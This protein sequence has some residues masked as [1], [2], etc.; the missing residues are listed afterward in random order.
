MKDPSR[1]ARFRRALCLSLLVIAICVCVYPY[2][3][4]Q[5]HRD[6]TPAERLVLMKPFDAMN[7]VILPF[8]KT[9]DLELDPSSAAFNENSSVPIKGV[10]GG[11][12]EWNCIVKQNS[13]R[14]NVHLKPMMERIEQLTQSG[15]YEEVKPLRQEMNRWSH[16]N[17]G[18]ELNSEAL[19]S[20]AEPGRNMELSI[21]GVAKG[22]VVADDNGA[23]VESNRYILAFG[24]WQAAKHDAATSAD[25]FHFVHQPQTPFVEN[26]V[27][28][29]SG[30]EDLIKE[31]LEKTDWIKIAGSLTR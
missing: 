25:R 30:A 14:F 9:H 11:A 15:R 26:M 31:L 7:A 19:D 21:A 28:T 18:L 4:A 16:L 12:F 2:A 17:I 27:I 29:I 24:N 23:P 8:L 6:P 10:I 3:G 1:I 5:S 20:G 22:F 13:D